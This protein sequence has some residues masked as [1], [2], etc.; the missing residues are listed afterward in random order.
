MVAIAIAI[1]NVVLTVI[2]IREMHTTTTG[3]AVAVVL[4][5]VVIFL[6]LAFLIVGVIVAIIA[7]ALSSGQ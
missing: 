7:A 6:I 4:I 5:P 3:R 1:Y 2:G